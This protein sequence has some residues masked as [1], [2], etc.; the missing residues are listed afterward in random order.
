MNKRRSS[1]AISSVRGAEEMALKKAKHFL[2]N[3]GTLRCKKDRSLHSKYNLTQK[4]LFSRLISTC[5]EDHSEKKNW[6]K[7]FFFRTWSKKFSDFGPKIFLH[8]NQNGKWL[9]CLLPLGKFQKKVYIL[10]KWFSFPNVLQRKIKDETFEK[11][12]IISHATVK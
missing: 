1:A 9:T 4:F 5:P 7:S 3:I 12:I 8:E 2:K 10:R 6:R 11:H